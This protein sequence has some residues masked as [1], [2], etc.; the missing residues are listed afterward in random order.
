M[1]VVIVGGGISGLATAY[2]LEKEARQNGIALQAT[3]VEKAVQLGGKIATQRRDGYIF[4]G[5]PESFVTRKPEA[6]ELCQELG[7]QD[8]LVGTTRPGKNYVLRNGRP[9]IV[10]SGP[11]TFLSTPLLSASGK[12]R[13]LKEPFV[14]PRTDASDESLGDFLRRRLG[15]EMVDNIV[16]P[17]IGSVY[18][19]DVDEMSVQVS[20]GRFAQME[21]QHGSVVKGMFG[22][23][24][25]KRAARK[26]SGEPRPARKPAFATLQNGLMEMIETLADQ[27]EGEILL[28]T[29]VTN[30]HHDLTHAQPYAL[31]LSNGRTL[32]ADLVVLATP[33]FVMADL[34]QGLVETAVTDQ[35]HAIP[36]NP[37]TTVNFAFNRNEIA[38]PFDGFGVVVPE[39]E[40]SQL[41]AV[42]GMSAKFPHRAPDDQFVL[43]AFVGGQNEPE[44]ASLPETELIKLV[45]HE[46]EQIF[47]IAAQPTQIHIQRWLPANPQP[48]VGHLVMIAQIEQTLAAHLPQLYLTGAGLRGQ[49][50]PDCIRQSRNLVTQIMANLQT[51][52][53][54]LAP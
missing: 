22:L 3:I 19:G 53:E 13:L 34:L 33:T 1:N 14:K 23:M 5:G 37:V 10:P 54:A 44:L 50:I 47:G 24:K 48:P 45:R 2:Y 16:K 29:A 12:L 52:T 6:W 7:L 39:N 40:S 11:G 21:Q 41:L 38:D 42:E 32:R 9:A 30:L 25:E 15:N 49:G 31:S 26:A 27:I 28:D 4:E 35:L 20:F 46:L 8:R 17:A 36:Y 43:R 51:K 18:L